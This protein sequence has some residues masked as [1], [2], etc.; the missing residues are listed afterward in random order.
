MSIVISTVPYRPTGL[1]CHVR[2]WH[3]VFLASYEVL[4]ECVSFYPRYVMLGTAIA[5]VATIPLRQKRY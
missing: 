3:R 5:Y 2:F 4:R 1:L